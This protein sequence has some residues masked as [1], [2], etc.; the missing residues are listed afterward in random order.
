M[1][2]KEVLLHEDQSDVGVNQIK[3][4]TGEIIRASRVSLDGINDAYFPIGTPYGKQDKPGQIRLTDGTYAA[5]EEIRR[6]RIAPA[7]RGI[8]A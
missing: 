3:L 7:V 2:V 8:D 6:V 5:M 4:A 1:G